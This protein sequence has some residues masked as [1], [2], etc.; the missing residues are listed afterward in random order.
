VSEAE[1]VTHRGLRCWGATQ[2]PCKKMN[3]NTGRRRTKRTQ[4]DEDRQQ[5]CGGSVCGS[6]ALGDRSAAPRPGRVREDAVGKTRPCRMFERSRAR[7]GARRC[8]VEA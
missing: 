6:E 3:L 2:H 8:R 5:R 7:R 1:T 4:P